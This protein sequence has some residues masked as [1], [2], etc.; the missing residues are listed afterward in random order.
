MEVKKIG[1]PIVQMQKSTLLHFSYPA[2]KF[3]IF[4]TILCG[5]NRLF[6]GRIWRLPQWAISPTLQVETPL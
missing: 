6:T 4:A 3:M 1:F 5:K 2:T